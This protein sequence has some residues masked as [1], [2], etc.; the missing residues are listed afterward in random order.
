MEEENCKNPTQR[1]VISLNETFY[2]AYSC[3]A[4]IFRSRSLA[5]TSEGSQNQIFLKCPWNYLVLLCNEKSLIIWYQLE[6]NI[7]GMSSMHC[8]VESPG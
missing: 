3:L 8:G 5:E 6:W 2:I 1:L 4:W 7:P